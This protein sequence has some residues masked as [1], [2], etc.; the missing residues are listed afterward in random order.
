MLFYKLYKIFLPNSPRFNFIHD[1][2]NI[3]NVKNIDRK[4]KKYINESDIYLGLSKTGLE[5]GKLIKKKIKSIFVRDPHL[6][7][8]FKMKFCEKNTMI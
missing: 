1:Y 2:L 6:I 8:F 7:L 5:T 3:L 4:T